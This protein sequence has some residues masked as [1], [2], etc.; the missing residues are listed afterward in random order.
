[1][2]KPQ[3]PREF[4]ATHQTLME[5]FTYGDFRLLRWLGE[6]GAGV[7]SDWILEQLKPGSNTTVNR[8]SI[9][10]DEIQQIIA[11]LTGATL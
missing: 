1:M 5:E 6:H 2:K 11:L 7:K 8:M 10:T 9:S 3:R 4:K